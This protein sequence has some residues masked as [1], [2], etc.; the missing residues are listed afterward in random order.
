MIPRQHPSKKHPILHMAIADAA[1]IIA[2]SAKSFHLSFS[3]YD[4]YM[5]ARPPN[6]IPPEEES[7]AGKKPLN[8][9]SFVK[10]RTVLPKKSK[11][12]APA[13]AAKNVHTIAFVVLLRSKPYLI[14]ALE[15]VQNINSE[16]AAIQKR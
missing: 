5:P 12:R 1:G 11:K 2:A 9:G 14:T 10:S 4:L 6:N 16:T 3:L 8:D 15:R 13:A 7:S